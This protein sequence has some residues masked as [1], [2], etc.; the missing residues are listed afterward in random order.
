MAVGR[1]CCCC[2]R[3]RLGVLEWTIACVEKNLQTSYCA[4]PL[5]FSH[6]SVE[7]QLTRKTD[8]VP[9]STIMT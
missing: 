7:L 2:A 9:L 6:P 5:Y 3:A 8:T 4:P 1:S